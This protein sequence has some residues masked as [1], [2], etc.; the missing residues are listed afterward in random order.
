MRIE[1][2][3]AVA[4]AGGWYCDDKAAFRSGDV[5]ID[6]YLVRGEPQTPGFR[7]VRE[8][9]GGLGVLLH[10]DGGPIAYGDGTSVTYAGAAGRDP[11]FRIEE[12]ASAFDDAVRPSLVGRNVD[13]FLD[14]AEVVEEL[15]WEGRGLHA[16]V[17]YAV[18]Q[19][20]LEAA[21]MSL[22]IAK[23]EVLARSYG[24]KISE[25]PIR[26]GIQSGEDR[27]AAVDKAIYRRVDVFPHGLIG[28]VARDLGHDGEKLIDYA[29]WIV[30]RLKEHDVEREFHPTVHFDC[31]GTIGQAFEC[32]VGR[33]RDY[34]MRLERTVAPLPLQIEAA[35]EMDSQAT[36]IDVLGRLRESLKAEGSGITLIADEWC[37]T[38]DDVS[39]FAQAGVV[40]MVQVKMPDLGGMTQSVEAVLKCHEHGLGAYLGGSCNETDLN[41]RNAVHLAVATGAEQVLAR[42]GMGVDEGVCIMRNEEARL[43]AMLTRPGVAI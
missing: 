4:I 9:G 1:D 18:S 23:A 20:L 22:G 3:Q 37:N 27:Y 41:A 29:T 24:L 40:D 25:R 16:A 35:V 19:A 21:A 17:R 6:G 14:L 30:A 39:R 28:N 7:A 2:V 43:R 31:Y 33:M 12:H 15:S 5:E 42:P 36:Q 34:L 38:L 32:D 10:L 11:V 8:V 26:L 13:D